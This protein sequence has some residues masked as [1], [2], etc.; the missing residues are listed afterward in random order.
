MTEKSVGKISYRNKKA[1]VKLT[2]E[3]ECDSSPD[4]VSCGNLVDVVDVSP[5]ESALANTK[6]E[7]ISNL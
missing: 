6:G 5:N 3:M 1:R 2:Y 7:I 4:E